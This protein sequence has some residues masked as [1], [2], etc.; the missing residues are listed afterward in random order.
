MLLEMMF[1]HEA[2]TERDA[3]T[4]GLDDVAGEERPRIVVMN[5]PFTTRRSNGRMRR[6]ADVAHLAAA[7]RMVAPGGRV[8]AVTSWNCQPE[9]DR[10]AKAFSGCDPQPGVLANV[11]ID[12]KMFRSRG[13]NAQTRLIVIDRDGDTAA[14]TITATAHD[15]ETLRAIVR[16]LAAERRAA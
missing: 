15:G 4:L 5:P 13:T 12:G 3:E 10:W 7:Y 16:E 1:G 11:V 9:G 8:A 6:Y 14:P 2:V